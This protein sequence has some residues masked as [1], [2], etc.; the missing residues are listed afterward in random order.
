MKLPHLFE[1]VTLTVELE[2]SSLPALLERGL[3]CVRQGLY[4]EGTAFFVLAREQL[5]SDCT[6]IANTLDALIQ[7]STNY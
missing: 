5:S 3:Q 6:H 7:S 2:G 4:A 1:Q